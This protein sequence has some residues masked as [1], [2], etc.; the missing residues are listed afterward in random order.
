MPQTDDSSVIARYR[1]ED[2]KHS[3]ILADRSKPAP[4][5]HDVGE[6]PAM[7]A[8]RPFS[9]TAPQINKFQKAFK[10]G[11]RAQG[12]C[13]HGS[14]HWGSFRRDRRR[15][16]GNRGHRVARDRSQSNAQGTPMP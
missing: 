10:P 8:L 1:I 11:S 14:Q 7:K 13:S 6:L 3:G 9:T 4:F 16:G 5:P 2:A 12:Q 15:C